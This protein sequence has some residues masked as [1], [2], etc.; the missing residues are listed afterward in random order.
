[1]QRDESLAELAKRYFQAHGPATAHDFAWW[2]GLTVSDSRAGAEA[3]GEALV[4]EQHD[5][6]TYWMA[7]E[8][9]PAPAPSG[10]IHLL[11][12]YDEHVVAY[13][14]HR[15]SLDPQIAGLVKPGDDTFFAHIVVRDGLVIGGWRR[16]VTKREVLVETDLLVPL[17]DGERQSL[18]EQAERFGRFLGLA[19]RVVERAIGRS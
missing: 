16:S 18:E 17:S 19:A 5:G 8:C 11:P 7:P 3:A 12:N 4:C 13:R 10:R 9:A 2:S 1:M 14:D 6:L 15:P